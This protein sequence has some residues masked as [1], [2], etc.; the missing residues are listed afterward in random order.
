M[1]QHWGSFFKQIRRF[2]AP[3]A[4]SIFL[5]PFAS[6]QDFGSPVDESEG[7]VRIQEHQTASEYAVPEENPH[8]LSSIFSP[9]IQLNQHCESPFTPSFRPQSLDTPNMIGDFLGY[10][11]S[12]SFSTTTTGSLET[13]DGV[14]DLPGSGRV[15]KIAEN[16]SPIP[17]D[18]VYLAYN[19]FHNAYNA[20]ATVNPNDID[21]DT[22]L[23]LDPANFNKQF[24]QNR[25]TLGLEKSF[26][27]GDMSVE[28]RMPLVTQVDYSV[29][30]YSDPSSKA[31]SF[32]TNDPTGNF[33]VIFKQVLFDW[34]G[35]ETAGV[36]TGGF[37]LT[38]A[39]ADGAYVQLGDAAFEV[40]DAGTHFSPYMALVIDSKK[41]WFIQ[42]FAEFDFSTDEIT[43]DDRAAGTV[44]KMDIPDVINL[45]IGM[46][47]WLHRFPERRIFKGLAPMIEYHY[48]G[49]RQDFGSV[50]FTSNGALSSSNVVVGAFDSRRDTS[51]LTAGVHVVLTDHIN[52]RV[53][54]VVPLQNAPDRQFDSEFVFQVDVV[55]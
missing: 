11:G 3:A 22:M 55:R 41:G 1:H 39:T 17:R 35:S 6:A 38:F 20:N 49:Q 43:I 45:D 53:A 25:F 27:Y 19:H 2:A 4:A 10:T 5:A 37:G 30:S 26:F 9:G 46:G 47:W 52:C 33:A 31:Y 23:P 24:D 29:P 13:V 36:F 50:A 7:L 15:P 54:G 32:G 16:N 12:V 8:S 34:Y 14:F 40:D 21:M 42:G 51:N 44:G 28:F 48:T 18:R